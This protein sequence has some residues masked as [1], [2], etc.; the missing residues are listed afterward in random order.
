M[1]KVKVS[2]IIATTA[3]FSSFLLLLPLV[4]EAQAVNCPTDSLQAA[5]DVATGPST[6]LV[7]G[8]CSENVIIREDKD[9][10][11]LDGQGMATISGPDNTRATIQIRG[12]GI[13]IRNFVSITG[14]QNGIQVWRRGAADI[15][16]NV[17]QSTGADGNG[18]VVNMHSFARIT[19]NTIQNNGNDGIQVSE[20]SSARV[21]FLSFNDTVAAPNTI[22]NNGRRGITVARS[23]NAIIIGNTITNNADDGVGVFRVSQADVSNNTIN[24]NG[25]DG[26]SVGQNS[27]V[28]L[29]ND[30][31]TLSLTYLMT[32][33]STTAAMGSEPSPIPLRT[34]VS[35]L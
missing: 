9:R 7:S 3:F 26:I 32:P 35:G 12:R 11:I 4:R 33:R 15:Q 27:G 10:L 23:S 6:I 1:E 31:G 19:N 24:G 25:G 17:I 18:I 13:S 28:N 20:N 2:R 30:T 34:G 22:Q 5:I 21:G 29:G 16:N 8:T 14:G